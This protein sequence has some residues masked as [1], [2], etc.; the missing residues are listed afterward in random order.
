MKIKKLLLQNF[1]NYENQIFESYN[2]N[3]EINVYDIDTQKT[4]KL[5]I[6][7]TNLSVYQGLLYYISSENSIGTYDISTGKICENILLNYPDEA[8]VDEIWDLYISKH[9]ISVIYRIG[10]VDTALLQTI[11]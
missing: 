9:G 11:P 6:T 8:R 5:G 4:K 3:N 1:R 2:S 10:I 7:G